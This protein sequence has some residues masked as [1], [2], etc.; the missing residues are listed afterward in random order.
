MTLSATAKNKRTIANNEHVVDVDF[1]GTIAC[2]QGLGIT[3]TSEAR[4][5]DLSAPLL[6]I[7]GGASGANGTSSK[8]VTYEESE[9]G[10]REVKVVYSGRTEAPPGR[11][12]SGCSV[13]DFQTARYLFTQCQVNGNVVT[14]QAEAPYPDFV[15]DGAML[16]TGLPDDRGC[17]IDRALP[18]VDFTENQLVA[19]GIGRCN[20]PLNDI[21]VTLTMSGS[22][23]DNSGNRIDVVLPSDGEIIGRD[24]DIDDEFEDGRADA[25]LKVDCQ[26]GNQQQVDYKLKVRVRF[27]HP[28]LPPGSGWPSA[29]GWEQV[30][31]LP[32]LPDESVTT[33]PCVPV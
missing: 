5:A 30:L 31:D 28:D 1:T 15:G 2:S 32:V 13:T 20:T 17:E 21:E 29:A 8:T 33:M 24:T 19:K 25:V 22:Y 3:G 11:T 23:V 6:D 7:R 14:W 10:G 4:L 16:D 12:W 27:K 9:K 26:E 18:S